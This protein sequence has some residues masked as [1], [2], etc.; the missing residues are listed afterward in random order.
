[1]L[2]VYAQARLRE[3]DLDVRRIG[4]ARVLLKVGDISERR[5]RQ[6][7]LWSLARAMRALGFRHIDVCGAA[8]V[9]DDLDEGDPEESCPLVQHPGLWVSDAMRFARDGIGEFFRRK[10]LKKYE[11]S[12]Q[13]DRKQLETIADASARVADLHVDKP[14]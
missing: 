10:E 14:I 2:S 6:H 5:I 8:G 3:A 13:Y 4:S 9:F 11:E 1:M 12:G 7:P